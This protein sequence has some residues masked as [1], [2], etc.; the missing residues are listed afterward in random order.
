MGVTLR[1]SP[2]AFT[3]L[4]NVSI[5]SSVTLWKGANQTLSSGKPQPVAPGDFQSE[6]EM[7]TLLSKWLRRVWRTH[8]SIFVGHILS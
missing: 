3:R 8:N 7:P 5:D 6:E 2:T 4:W 1:Q